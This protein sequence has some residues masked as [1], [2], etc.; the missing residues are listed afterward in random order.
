[1]VKDDTN[2]QKQNH[3]RHLKIPANDKN[4]EPYWCFF[5]I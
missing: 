4:L 3:W 1:M 2:L 5:N